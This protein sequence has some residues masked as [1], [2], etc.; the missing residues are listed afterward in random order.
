[1]VKSADENGND[2][3]VDVLTVHDNGVKDLVEVEMED[4][5]KIRCTLDHKFRTLNGMLSLQE[6]IDREL[7]IIHEIE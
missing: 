1:V 5:R 7:E 3:W 6:I 4:G 2:I